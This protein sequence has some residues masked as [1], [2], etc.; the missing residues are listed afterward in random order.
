MA[1][2]TYQFCEFNATLRGTSGYGATA[3]P[4]G[5]MGTEAAQCKPHHQPHCDHTCTSGP[6]VQEPFISETYLSPAQ[7]PL[8]LPH[9]AATITSRYTPLLHPN[10]SI[11]PTALHG[12]VVEI[13]DHSRT[14]SG[15]GPPAAA[16]A[17]AATAVTSSC[18]CLPAVWRVRRA[19]PTLCH[20]ALCRAEVNMD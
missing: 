9:S 11:F 4:P 5:M 14:D 10:S 15:I 1:D 6:I 12:L 13:Y 19:S 7:L 16:A 20:Y 2:T 17:A 3:A 8:S 18:Y